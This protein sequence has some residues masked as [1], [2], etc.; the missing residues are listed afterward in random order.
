MLSL[1]RG[2]PKVLIMESSKLKQLSEHLNETFHTSPCN[3]DA[4]FDNA[5][6]DFTIILLV[7]KLSDIVQIN[8]VK[9]FYLINEDSDVLLCTI[10]NSKKFS[11]INHVRTAP[12]ILIMRAF[13]NL[14]KVIEGI[15]ND[16][17]CITGSFKE[18]FDN[19]DYKGTILA[20]TQHPLNKKLSYTELYPTTL[21]IR[22]KY[23]P[24]RRSLR[25]HGLRYLNEGLDNKDWYELEIKIYDK[26][27][28]FM[29]HY[30]R[31]LKILEYL[32]LGIILGESWGQDTA[33]IFNVV[34][35]YRVRFFTFYEPDYIKKILL[36]L[37]YLDDETR[38]V[39]YDVF[40]KRRKISWTDVK[41]DNIKTKFA[42]SQ[43]YRKHIMEKLDDTQLSKIIELE[44]QI[45]ATRY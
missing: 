8:D 32:E 28:A 33:L 41:E 21:F 19:Y 31:L 3:M 23:S 4:A 45:I 34:G 35:I 17:P 39:D 2:G 38:I 9:Y 22:E 18:I 14:E 36:G 37:E 24:L 42:L 43:K 11:L 1:I 15:K 12:R 6:E 25:I 40:L 13:G 5:T 16:Y 20:L 29:L 27:E 44:K 10:H 30:H 7:D 26:Y